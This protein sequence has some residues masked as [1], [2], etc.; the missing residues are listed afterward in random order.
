MR[1]PKGEETRRPNNT[2]P[3]LKGFIVDQQLVVWCPYCRAFH[4]HGLDDGSVA[5]NHHRVAHCGPMTRGEHGETLIDSPFRKG[6]YYIEPFTKQEMREIAK[7][8][9][10]SLAT[11][12]QWK[13]IDAH[14]FDIPEGTREDQL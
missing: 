7:G 14:R 1:R 13:Y 8:K 11:S 6:G 3:V 4:H 5:M 2:K 12:N 10:A 9:L